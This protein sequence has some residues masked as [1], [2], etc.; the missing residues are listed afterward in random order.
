MDDDLAILVVAGAVA[1]AVAAVAWIGDRR[2][3]RRKNADDVGFMPWTGLFFVGLL[4]ALVLIGLA[5][6]MWLAA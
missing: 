1:L 3:T 4:V 5:A 2:R 6:R